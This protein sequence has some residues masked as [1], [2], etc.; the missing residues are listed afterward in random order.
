MPHQ[1]LSQ[2]LQLEQHIR[3]ADC[4]TVLSFS[5]VNQTRTL[6]PTLAQLT[7]QRFQD[8]QF[9]FTPSN[10][11]QAIHAFDGVCFLERSAHTSRVFPSQL[12]PILCRSLSALA[13]C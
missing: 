9:P 1:V 11:K 6:S 2:L 10:A 13:V 4:L 12:T 3:Q 7:V 8:M 5:I